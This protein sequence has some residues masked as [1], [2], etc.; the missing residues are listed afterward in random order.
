MIRRLLAGAAAVVLVELFRRAAE[1]DVTRW[2]NLT[3]EETR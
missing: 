3:D 2:A 1:R